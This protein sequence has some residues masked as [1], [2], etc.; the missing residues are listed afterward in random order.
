MTYTKKCVFL[1]TKQKEMEE[2]IFSDVTI[3]G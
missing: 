2:N 1:L 3:E